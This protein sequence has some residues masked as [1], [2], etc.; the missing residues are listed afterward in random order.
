MDNNEP[1]VWRWVT[2]IVAPPIILIT[3]LGVL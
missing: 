3:V 1:H 2:S